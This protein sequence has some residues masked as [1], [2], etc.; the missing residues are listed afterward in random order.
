MVTVSESV[1]DALNRLFK[2]PDYQP[3]KFECRNCGTVVHYKELECTECGNM[4]AW[5]EPSIVQRENK[6]SY[7][8]MV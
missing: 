7:T 5:C 3:C 1:K 2:K 8:I 4:L 6:I